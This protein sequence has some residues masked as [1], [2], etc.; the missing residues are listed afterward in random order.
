MKKKGGGLWPIAVGELLWWL[1]S[2]CISRVVRVEA[3]NILFP[4]QVGVG[5]PMGCEPVVHA[6]N[7]VQDD[8]QIPSGAKWS[9]LLDFSNTFNCD[10]REVMFWEVRTC[11]PS[12]SAWMECCSGAQPLLHFGINNPE[13]LWYP[14]GWPFGSFSVLPCPF[15]PFWKALR[16]SSLLC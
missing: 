4:L 14:T 6:M 15:T 7:I 2:N 11:I 8:P 13:L 3:S 9:L 16:G 1:T 12:I 5:V 10:N